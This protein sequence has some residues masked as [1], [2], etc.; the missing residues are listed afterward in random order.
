MTPAT[1]TLDALLDLLA[2]NN[3]RA[4]MYGQAMGMQPEADGV[5]AIAATLRLRAQ[6]IRDA[7]ATTE[8]DVARFAHGANVMRR[9]AIRAIN[10]PDEP[11]ATPCVTCGGRG[12]VPT[13]DGVGLSLCPRCHPMRP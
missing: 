3:E 9:D 10:A 13:D 8:A 2:G 12:H 4:A 6:R 11:P 1:L 5:A 7:I